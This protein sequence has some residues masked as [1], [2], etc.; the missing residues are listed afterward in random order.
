MRFIPAAEQ[1]GI[2]NNKAARRD[3]WVR[4]WGIKCGP[5]KRDID[6]L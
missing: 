5:T 2:Q 1:R 6:V 3:D 4:E